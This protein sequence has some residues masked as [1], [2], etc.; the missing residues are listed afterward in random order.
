MR[1]K[2]PHGADQCTPDTRQAARWCLEA[3]K[4]ATLFELEHN[5]GRVCP[6]SSAELVCALACWANMSSVGKCLNGRVWME[7]FECWNPTA[8]LRAAA[9]TCSGAIILEA[10]CCLLNDNIFKDVPS[11]CAGTKPPCNLHASQQRDFIL[12]SWKMYHL[13]YIRVNEGLQSHFVPLFLKF[14]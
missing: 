1:L 12:P 2:S 4:I 6:T 9:V 5:Q 13:L 8:A 7:M 14:T 11:I 3:K 10:N